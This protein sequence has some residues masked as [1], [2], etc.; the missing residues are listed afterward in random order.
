MSS[1]IS[2]YCIGV[3]YSCLKYKPLNSITISLCCSWPLTP[4]SP[5][6][7]GGTQE[8]LDRTL[9]EEQINKLLENRDKS[10]VLDCAYSPKESSL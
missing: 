2:L 6:H 7:S 5:Q 1:E 9:E 10:S 8:V 4:G 3:C